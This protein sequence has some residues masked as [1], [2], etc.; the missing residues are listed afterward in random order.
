MS[1]H[2]RVILNGRYSNWLTNEVER[3]AQVWRECKAEGKNNSEAYA[4]IAASLGRSQGSVRAR[5]EKCGPS[6]LSNSPQDRLRMTE[7]AVP[8]HAP[9]M[10][11]VPHRV[12]E[13]REVRNAALER[14]DTTAQLM[15]DPPPGFSAL[16]ERERIRHLPLRHPLSATV[17]LDRYRC[18]I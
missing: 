2:N 5:H 4:L 11:Y 1:T 8:G 14:R 16:D 7:R 6:F 9:G 12:L 10:T 15:N 13:L 18:R 3:A 17:T